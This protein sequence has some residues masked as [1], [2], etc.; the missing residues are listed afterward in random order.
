MPGQQG[1]IYQKR[2]ALPDAAAITAQV[3]RSTRRPLVYPVRKAGNGTIRLYGDY[4]G[5]EDAT[6]DIKIIDTVLER[7]TVS[8]PV[9]R[10]A[11]TG[12][13]RDIWVQGLEAQ[14]I[15]VLCLS[16]GTDTVQAEVEIEGLRF[17]ARPEGAEGNRIYI[18][19]DD[20][21]LAFSETDYSLLKDLSPGDTGLSGQEW[22]W[23]TKA[24]QGE[25]VPLDAHRV[26]FGQ[27]RVHVYLQYKVFEDGEWKYHFIPQIRYEARTG[28]K[29]YFVSGG[30][31]ITVTD[32]VTTEVFDGIITVADLWQ[33]VKEGSTLIEPVESSIDTSRTVT[34]PAVRELAVKT[35]AYFLP[36]YRDQG[37][38]EYAGVLENVG[39]TNDAKTELIELTCRDN[40]YIGQEIWDV[41]GSASG[42]LG[43]VRTGQL[44][45][46]GF[47]HFQIPKRFPKDWGTLKEGWSYEVRYMPREPGA[48][49]P[50]ICFTMRLGIASSP[51]RM[52]LEYKRRPA[53]CYC[54]PVGFSDRC[55]GFEE[56]GGD[57][58]MAYIVPDLLFWTDAVAERMTE[59]WIEGYYIHSY[60]GGGS[61]SYS[62]EYLEGR[63][64]YSYRYGFNKLIQEYV[65]KFKTLAQR[66]M[67]LPEDDES[68]LRVM[69]DE[70]KE[71]VN[72]LKMWKDDSSQ[73]ILWNG[74][75]W[76]PAPFPGSVSVA[77]VSYDTGLYQ[78]LVDRVLD[79]ERTYG[80][81]KNRIIASGT[82]YQDSDDEYYWEVRGA[83][84]YL[85]AY[86]DV[87]YYSTVRSGDE[88][89]N[90]REFAFLISTPCGGVLK[91]GDKIEVSIG[92][93]QYEHTYQVGDRTF[94]PTI[95]RQELR[96]SGG[97]D[98]DDTYR[99]GV[100]GEIDVF[101]DY[102]LD[103]N[104]PA[105]YVHPRLR[106]QIDEGAVP[107]KV[108]DSFSFSVEGGRF[109]WRKNGGPWSSPVGVEKEIQPF[110]EGLMIGFEFGVSPS[111]MIDDTWE[112]LC[113]QDNKAMNMA[114]LNLSSKYRGNGYV[115][116][117]MG[118]AVS[119]DVLLIDGHN[120]AGDFVFRASNTADF[121]TT[122]FSDTITP[123]P[124]I[125]RLYPAISARY[126]RFEFSGDVEIGY[127]FLGQ[128]TRLSLDADRVT[129]LRRYNM[130]RQAG[131]EPF[132]LLRYV[133]RG[134]LVGY[135]SFLYSSDW[136]T[137]EGMIDYL[138]RGGDLPMYFIPN[139][140]Y[141]DECIRVRIDTDLLEVS[142]DIDMNAPKDMRLFALT[143]PLAGT[144]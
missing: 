120:I 50:P 23:D 44:A 85:D 2:N 5:A 79:Y 3:A 19:V 87:P 60:P 67:N 111:F 96:L 115:T 90:T 35:D 17:R 21:E 14:K 62:G 98:G 68:T 130:D 114:G 128:V 38:S 22:D 109:I 69:V 108:G 28:E 36:P 105:Q 112:V 110:D 80:V 51:Q 101:P 40:S 99:W 142:G 31:R 8:A 77:D 20:S 1:Y 113:I 140:S 122:V 9:F 42:E 11:G 75:D 103:R 58:G 121:S 107:F 49:P 45:N 6:Y 117:D 116:I 106:F 48:E 133:H 30:R 139:I 72:S 26:A 81:K 32:G 37:S 46:F 57:A 71:L 55:L 94:L 66:I 138:K 52:V 27:N 54:P 13:M 16:T 74:S 100:S 61:R 97:I 125:C 141:P 70:Y 132:S 123:A 131:K 33:A 129:P 76:S 43:Q 86:T 65:D 135:E 18:T 63:D 136:E 25:F 124:V 34:S 4:T 134:Y 92:E 64:I 24:L 88:Y 10:G 144:E 93:L 119:I 91:E 118:S 82:C 89:V 104:A 53:D 137:L 7:P 84:A 143:I 126:Y 41:K 47:V 78:T 59:K 15:T 29:V 83:R 12:R 56:E 127:C 39:V 73:W 102:L 95:A